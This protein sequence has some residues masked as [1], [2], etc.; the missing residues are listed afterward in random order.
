MN[1]ILLDT[2]G[3]SALTKNHPHVVRVL[4]EAEAIFMNPVILGELWAGF[5]KGTQ[6]EKNERLLQSFLAK[7]EIE[8]L[9]ID[10]ETAER[11]AL[12]YDYLRKSGTPVSPN[13][14]WIAATA[15][16]HGLRVLTTDRDFQKIPQILI[17]LY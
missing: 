12:I 16:Q 1:G 7:E 17:D 3:Y 14:L 13:D 8:T 11:Y 9:S 4:T 2:S 10:A 6:Q 5:R 15:M